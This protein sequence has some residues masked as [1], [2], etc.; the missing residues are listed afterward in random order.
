MVKVRVIVIALSTLCCAAQKSFAE[1]VEMQLELARVECGNHMAGL[2]KKTAIWRWVGVGIAALG[3]LTAS[4]AGLTASRSERLRTRKRWGYL[5]LVSGA[6]AAASP[7]L[8]KGEEFRASLLRSDKHYI[9]GFKVQRQLPSLDPAKSFRQEGAKYALARFTDCLAE[10]PSED[11]PDLPTPG[12]V[13]G[14]VQHHLALVEGPSGRQNYSLYHLGDGD[15][16][17]VPDLQV[18]V[19]VRFFERGGYTFARFW[20]EPRGMA[21]LQ[22]P[23]VLGPGTIEFPGEAG[24]YILDV[25]SLSSK[26]RSASVRLR[27]VSREIND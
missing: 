18:K 19:G 25:L 4:V 1:P 7:F 9:V 3:G 26:D 11:V 6:L 5:A 27:S 13:D 22:Q 17:S 12:Q 10:E 2:R 23:P 15:I 24:S 14:I 21:S 8:P 20:I 16:I